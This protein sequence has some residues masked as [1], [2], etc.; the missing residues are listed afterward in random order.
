MKPRYLIPGILGFALIG[1]PALAASTSSQGNTPQGETSGPA[2]GQTTTP[3]TAVEK[4]ATNSNPSAATGGAGIEGKRGAEAGHAPS[5][6]QAPSN[7]R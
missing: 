2:A 3:S 4:D 6:H 5:G 1:A 7:A